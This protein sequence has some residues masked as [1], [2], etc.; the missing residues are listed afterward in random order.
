MLHLE[1]KPIK[2]GKKYKW[3]E[4]KITPEKVYSKRYCS[5]TVGYKDE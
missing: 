2:S 5:L 4:I 1:L 3:A